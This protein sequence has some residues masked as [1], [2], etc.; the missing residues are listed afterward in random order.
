MSNLEITNSPDLFSEVLP[1]SSVV[2]SRLSLMP[3]IQAIRQWYE[4]YD[5]RQRLVYLLSY[6]DHLLD[7]MGYTRADLKMVSKL[8]LSTD[9]H[10]ILKELSDQRR[11]HYWSV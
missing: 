6:D 2:R 3:L 1:K 11:R 5:R 8:P 7:D 10:Q 4:R 9:A